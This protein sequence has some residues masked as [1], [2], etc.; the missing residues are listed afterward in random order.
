MV[1]L[2]SYV[3]FQWSWLITMLML[4]MVPGDWESKTLQVQTVLNLEDVSPF[5]E[6]IDEANLRLWDRPTSRKNIGHPRDWALN[7]L[8]HI[9]KYIYIYI[10]NGHIFPHITDERALYSASL[11]FLRQCVCLGTAIR[12]CIAGRVPCSATSAH[13]NYLH[14]VEPTLWVNLVNPMP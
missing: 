13:S 4:V 10:S 7:P 12:C 6:G 5:L 11:G 1:L 14:G 3:E 8:K 9:N 2:C